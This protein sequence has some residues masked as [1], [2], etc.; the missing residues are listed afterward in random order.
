[1][2]NDYKRMWTK[3]EI[4]SNSVVE[5]PDI[6][7]V[8]DANSPDII[9]V[10]GKL[11]YKDIKEGGSDLTNTK[12]VFNETIM[13]TG[14]TITANINYFD[15][16]NKT[17]IKIIISTTNI[18][19]LQTNAPA[20]YM[21]TTLY[22]PNTDLGGWGKQSY[23]TI[24]ITGGD[25]VTNVD[26]ITF[27]KENAILLEGGKTTYNYKELGVEDALVKSI[28]TDVSIIED[29]GKLE[30]M[31]EHD[32]NVLAV[33]DTPNQFLQRRLDKPSAVWTPSNSQTLKEWLND[34]WTH[35]GYIGQYMS[36][37]FET[38]TG[39]S[40]VQQTKYG[41]CNFTDFGG[42]QVHIKPLG[43]YTTSSTG[44]DF[45]NEIRLFIPYEKLYVDT[46]SGNYIELPFSKVTNFKL[47]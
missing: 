7:E 44:S 9:R 21:T 34:N 36:V 26:L 4:K 13:F 3:E 27:L 43:I 28:A 11:Y 47:Y 40:G 41:I 22:D 12:W 29:Q 2:A 37:T 20:D 31:L 33:N 46:T 5:L 35:V 45:I 25:D 19:G 23:R 17:F 15:S 16:D 18:N 10:Q 42:P 24:T 1:M 32:G 14:T 8:V 39:E 30:L 6:P 38:Y